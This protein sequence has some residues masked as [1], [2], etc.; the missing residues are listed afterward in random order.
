MYH[1]ETTHINSTFVISFCN[2]VRRWIRSRTFKDEMNPNYETADGYEET[3]DIE[4]WDAGG[5][6]RRD[7]WEETYGY[8]RMYSL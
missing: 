2:I 3:N 5:N 4:I 6:A 1:T 7:T 8:D